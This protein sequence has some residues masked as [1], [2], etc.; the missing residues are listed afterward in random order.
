MFKCSKNIHFEASQLQI[1]FL[2]YIRQ[3]KSGQQCHN[4]EKVVTQY[5]N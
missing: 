3:T 4:R 5:A 2:K 1:E